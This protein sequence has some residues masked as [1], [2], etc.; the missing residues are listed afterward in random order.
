[1]GRLEECFADLAD[2]RSGN[3]RHDLLELL[4]IALCAVL[5]GAESCVEMA[6][7]GASKE[8]LLRQFLKLE[9]GVPSHD[10][11]SRVFRLLEPGAF[12]AAFSRFMAVFVESCAGVVA[13]DGKTA[14]R[15]FDRASAASPLHLLSAWSCEQRLVLAQRKVEADGNEITAIGALLALLDLDGRLVTADAMHCQRDTAQKII[16]RDG[17]YVLA[18]KANQPE[19]LE[20]VRLLLDDPAA[21][22][23][24]T[25]ETVDGDHGRIETRQAAVL[26]DVDFLRRD[27]EWPGLAAVGKI[28]A[29]RE[30]D[31]KTSTAIRYYLLSKPLPA[32]RF[33]EVVRAHWGIENN[34]H[35]VLDVL[36]D[37]DQARNRKDNGPENLALLRRLALNLLRTN[38]DKG[39]LRGKIK[40]AGWNDAFLLRLLANA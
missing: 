1:M 33:L 10:T 37:E 13:I 25:A 14:R 31:G 15:S 40:R 3:A 8:P 39:S 20:D 35:W 16:D 22:P 29:T 24:D 34:L 38:K 11:F 9:H 17:G 36:L 27:H 32:K 30:I 12:H 2:P 4:T 18:L 19:L 21:P 23:D 28:T 7:F 26:S 6:L 5:C